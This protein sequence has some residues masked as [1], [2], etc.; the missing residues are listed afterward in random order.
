MSLYPSSIG[1]DCADI[2]EVEPSLKD[3][4]DTNHADISMADVLYNSPGIHHNSMAA[5]TPVSKRSRIL[6]P[7]KNIALLLSDEPLIANCSGCRSIDFVSGFDDDPD[8]SSSESEESSSDD[9]NPADELY[10]ACAVDPDLL[11]G[12]VESDIVRQQ[13]VGLRQRLR[14]RPT[15]P[16]KPD[17]SIM[18]A[19]DLNVGMKLPLYSCPFLDCNFTT[20]DRHRFLHHV[21]GSAMDATH[22]EHK[23][24]LWK[25]FCGRI[26]KPRVFK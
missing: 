11:R 21:A 3:T 5:G 2:Q 17:G 9:E 22:V 12:Q 10:F 23:Q 14:S 18:S 8:E 4:D 25:S 16:L 24:F 1:K 13:C 15:L 26:L 19:E 6:P 7:A 20:D